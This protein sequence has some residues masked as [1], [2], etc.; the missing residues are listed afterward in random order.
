[1]PSPM[2]ATKE[3]PPV[4]PKAFPE[5]KVKA[6]LIRFWTDESLERSKDPFA[7]APKMS[8]TLYDLLPELDSLTIVQSFLTVEKILGLKIPVRL[9]RSGGYKSQNEF[10]AD[11][12]PKFRN[13]FEKQI[14]KVRA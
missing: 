9:I 13:H 2:I 1:M 3:E 11:L 5:S 7:P 6:A 8:G 4:R 14:K 12:L 10:L